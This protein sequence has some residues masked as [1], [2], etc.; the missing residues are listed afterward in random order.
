M[1]TAYHQALNQL[2]ADYLESTDDFQRTWL[3][4]AEK[5]GAEKE[6]FD[7]ARALANYMQ[8][9]SRLKELAIAAIR[10]TLPKSE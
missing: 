2:L 6:V 3:L 5:F 10:R 7:F 8:I 4:V 1:S 9:N